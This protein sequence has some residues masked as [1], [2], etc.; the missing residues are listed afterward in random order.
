MTNAI[1]TGTR[2]I[3]FNAPVDERD[4]LAR[5][6][7][8]GNMGALIRRL[9]F[10]GLEVENP[11]AAQRLRDIRR[12]YYG[13]TLLALTLLVTALE[14]LGADQDLRRPRAQRVRVCRVGRRVEA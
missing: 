3:P 4:L 7:G 11:E 5:I 8:P 6:A 9:I 14:W 1:G 10:R 13:A 2:N 12:Q